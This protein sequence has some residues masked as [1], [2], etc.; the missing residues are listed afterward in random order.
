[1]KAHVSYTKTNKRTGEG[2]EPEDTQRISSR[3][4]RLFSW[5]SNDKD[6]TNTLLVKKKKKKRLRSSF[7]G[8]LF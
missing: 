4:E 5:I 1:M 2:K 6:L 8:V 3:A 7:L